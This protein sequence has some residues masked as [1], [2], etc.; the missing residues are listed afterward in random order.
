MQGSRSRALFDACLE[1][2]VQPT[3]SAVRPALQIGFVK[4]RVTPDVGEGR[5]KRRFRHQRKIKPISNCDTG[6]GAP[7]PKGRIGCE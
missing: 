7:C 3:R 2:R 4:C 1:R 6:T 5:R